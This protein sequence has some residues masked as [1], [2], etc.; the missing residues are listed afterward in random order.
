MTTMRMINLPYSGPM[1][2]RTH[3]RPGRKFRRVTSWVSGEQPITTSQRVPM[4]NDRKS[5]QKAASGGG[6]IMMIY[7]PMMMMMMMMMMR[8]RR[9][10][11]RLLMRRR[12]KKA[13]T[14]GRSGTPTTIP[15]LMTI[16]SRLMVN[17]GP[18]LW[19]GTGGPSI[20]RHDGTPEMVR[21]HDG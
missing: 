11:P 7:G 4:D 14:G 9:R 17:G 1:R 20:S 8:R 19:M 2:K 13:K 6:T 16:F 5:M 21:R 15:F 18:V 12:K 10:L 3:G